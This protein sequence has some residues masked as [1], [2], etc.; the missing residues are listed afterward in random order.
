MEEIIGVDSEEDQ[1][2]NILEKDI[3]QDNQE[4]SPT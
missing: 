3:E 2:E 1:N 4:F